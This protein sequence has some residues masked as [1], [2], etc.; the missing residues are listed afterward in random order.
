MGLM[1]SSRPRLLTHILDAIRSYCLVVAVYGPLSNNDYVQPFLICTVLKGHRS[2]NTM[3]T[4]ISRKRELNRC[5]NS[6]YSQINILT[7]ADNQQC[8]S[9][10]YVSSRGLKVALCKTSKKPFFKLPSTTSSIQKNLPLSGFW[11][12]YPET[13]APDGDSAEMHKREASCFH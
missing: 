11:K 7:S 1:A 12:T 10:I 3:G 5:V 8:F 4:V 6:L 13:T 2:N 9:P